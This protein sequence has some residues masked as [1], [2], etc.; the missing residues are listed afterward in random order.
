M[1]EDDYS[2]TSMATAAV[3]RLDSDTSVT[4]C[5]VMCSRC[6]RGMERG[7]DGQGCENWSCA[8]GMQTVIAQQ[9]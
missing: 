5:G 1:S 6:T 3:L 7:P 4:I 8:C 9:N 2:P